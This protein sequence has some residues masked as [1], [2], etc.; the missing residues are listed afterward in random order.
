[1]ETIPKV[2]TIEP[3]KL[4]AELEKGKTLDLPGIFKH[5]AEAFLRKMELSGEKLCKMKEWPQFRAMYIAG[6]GSGGDFGFALAKKLA[7]LPIKANAENQMEL[8]L[9]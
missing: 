8:P 5:N 4:E 6:Y 1:M 9:K 7:A 2:G 3:T